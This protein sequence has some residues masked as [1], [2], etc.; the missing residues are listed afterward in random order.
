MK[1]LELVPYAQQKRPNLYPSNAEV[2][3]EDVMTIENGRVLPGDPVG[4]AIDSL[5]W[6]T[7]RGASTGNLYSLC[8]RFLTCTLYTASALHIFEISEA[9]H[10]LTAGEYRKRGW[11]APP[12]KPIINIRGEVYPL[13]PSY[14]SWLQ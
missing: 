8:I 13:E 5:S 1:S 12:I 6:S 10:S 11:G 9:F 7:L 2:G 14:Y 3:L 4:Q